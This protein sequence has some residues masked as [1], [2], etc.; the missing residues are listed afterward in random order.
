MKTY[1]FSCA[2]R[3]EETGELMPIEGLTTPSV[4]CET[5]TQ[6]IHHPDTVAYCEANKCVI[7]RMVK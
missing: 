7:Y 6:A 5:P 2:V 1:R 3:I 4:T